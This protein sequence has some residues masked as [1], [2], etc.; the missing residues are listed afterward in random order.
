M[1]D[2]VTPEEHIEDMVRE[3]ADRAAA[4]EAV[5]KESIIEDNKKFRRR[6]TVLLVLVV[7]L[8]VSQAVQQVRYYTTS[9]PQNDRIEDA[10]N[11]IDVN[12]SSLDEITAFIERVENDNNDGVTREELQVVFKAV[13]ETRDMVECV[14]TAEDDAAV[15]AC[16]DLES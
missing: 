5:T 3:V 16:A 7:M 14:L 2:D 1:T 8:L 15:R 13:F 9:K 4:V 12:Q 6:N 11:A 10:I